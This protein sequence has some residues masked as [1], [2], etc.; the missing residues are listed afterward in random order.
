MVPVQCRIGY[1]IR[2]GSLYAGGPEVI[3][4]AV[5]AAGWALIVFGDVFGDIHAGV[6]LAEPVHTARAHRSIA[7]AAVEV[8]MDSQI[9]REDEWP[10]GHVSVAGC[11]AVV[12]RERP[13]AAFVVQPVPVGQVKT[14][15]ELNHQGFEAMVAS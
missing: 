3:A 4:M 15:Q 7:P 14:G 6:R 9:C 2:I 10:P 12:R 8:V 1:E 11:V 5:G 13:W